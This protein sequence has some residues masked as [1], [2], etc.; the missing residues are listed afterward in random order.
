MTSPLIIRSVVC[1]LFSALFAQDALISAQT[2]DQPPSIVM[3]WGDRPSIRLGTAARIDLRLNLQVDARESDAALT[4]GGSV[5][6]AR[7]RVGVDGVLARVL[8][9]QVEGEIDEPNPWRDVYVNYQ[10]FEAVQLQAGQFK[11]PF[12]LEQTT[13]AAKL[14]FVYRSRAAAL[15]AP[16]RDRGVMAHGRVVADRLRYEAGVFTRDGDNARRP[17]PERLAGGRTIAARVSARPFRS[18][19]SPWRTLEAGVAG[20][21]SDIAEGFP[22]IQGETQLGDDFYEAELWVRGSLRRRGVELRWRPGPFTLTSEYIRLAVERR[23][24][25]VE[26]TDLSPFVADGWYVSG[27][28]AITGGTKTGAFGVVEAAVRIEALEFSSEGTGEPASASPR[29]EVVLGRRIDALTIGANWRPMRWLKVQVNAVRE[30]VT[31]SGEAALPQRP[32]WSQV[33]R[34][35]FAW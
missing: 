20:T 4:P 15:L 11:L 30:V 1:A 27:T 2:S 29:A 14:D 9:F 5:A 21:W 22:G 23:A 33:L 31:D 32:L 18:A 8:G 16:G 35:Q 19:Q 17:G 28:W 13:S 24:Q 26:E 34:L 6:W 12:S 7:K 3:T 25:S 10:Q